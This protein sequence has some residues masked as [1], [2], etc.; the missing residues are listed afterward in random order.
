MLKIRLLLF[1][2]LCIYSYLSF[3]QSND[4]S[5][6]IIA[7]NFI[8]AQRG[9]TIEFLV[10]TVQPRGEIRLANAPKGASLDDNR[11]FTWAIPEY[12]SKANAIL[13]FYLFIDEVMVDAQSVF[14]IIQQPT[15]EPQIELKSNAVLQNGVYRINPTTDFFLEVN[16]TNGNPKDTTQVTLDYYFNENK[17]LKKLNN[18]KIELE[19]NNLKIQWSPNQDQIKHKYYRMTV[20]ATD[21]HHVKT[22][23]VLVFAL[24]SNNHL[25]YFKFPVLDEYYIS[26][27]ETLSIDMSAQDMDH[28]SLVYKL[29]IP[30]KIGNPKLSEKGLFT[31]K[32]NADELHRLR[33]YFPMEVT[34]EVSE[35]GPENPNTIS[36]TFLIRKS[37]RNEPPR[38]LN[39]QNDKVYEGIALDKKVFIQDG[40]DLFSDLEVDIIGAPEGMVWDF[41][42]NLLSID[43]T[44]GFD[45]V[46]VEMQP[47]KFDMLLVVRDP[48]GYV[49]QKAFTITVEHRENTA[50]TYETYLEY[51]D[52]AVQ[53]IEFLSQINSQMEDREN[54]VQSLKKGLSVMSM[55]LAV[56]TASGNVFDDGSTAKQLVPFV[57]I[58]AAVTTG[59]NAFG[60][61][62]LPKFGS[63]RE[64][65]FILQQKLMYILAILNEYKI[66]SPN[67]PNLENKEFRDNLATYEQWMVQDKLN[68][69]S[70]Y[71]KYKS[72]N[73]VKKNTQ[74]AR[75]KAEKN[76]T[77]PTGLLF[78]NLN[79][80]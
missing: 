12:Y 48:H 62:D 16:A 18:V 6:L 73:F 11:K 5:K 80:I 70:Y 17:D 30:S 20:V 7:N 78:I 21:H 68:F 14:V 13:N 65:T 1:I 34:V 27:G 40:N 55:F 43:W 23:Q 54:K 75:H 71:S 3:S 51:R 37:I 64:Q 59:I 35:R 79:E 77:E 39:L 9:E 60:F 24:S 41:Q 10:G 44:P 72:L 50:V 19:K 61:N 76:G 15:Q 56:Y 42:N 47:K 38:I 29:I 32:L 63:I 45:V 66:E 46:G 74:Q 57:G 49:D 36:K 2:N 31:Y 4:S 26:D 28:D 52:D 8:Q 69:K 53:L 25:P 22:E 58:M 67:S 33:S